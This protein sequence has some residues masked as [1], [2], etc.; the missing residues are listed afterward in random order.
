M[1]P[2]IR[3]VSL[4]ANI[5]AGKPLREVYPQF[6]GIDLPNMQQIESVEWSE[7]DLAICGL[8][9]GTAQDVIK[10]IPN[11]VRI[12]D[13]SAD[14]RLNDGNIYTKWY[15]RVHSAPE[16][17]KESVYGLSEHYRDK[18]KEARIVACPGCYPAAV[19]T[20]L[21]PLIQDGLIHPQDLIIDAKSGITGAGRS[22][23]ES[24]LFCELAESMR[25]YNV[26]HHRHIPEI[27]QEISHVA[28]V[29]I[30]V[31]FTPHLIPMN[32]GEL[33]TIYAKINTKKVENIRQSLRCFYE[34]EPFVKVLEENHIPATS[35]V[36]GSNFCLLGVFEDRLAGRVILISVL[37]NLVKGSSGQAVQNMNIMFGFDEMTGLE[38]HPLYP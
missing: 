1:H 16:L 21:L 25:P 32:G 22:L 7:V 12:I 9:H 29:D 10:K 26:A 14:F 8:P 34:D 35:H 38:Q 5:H 2:Y 30:L 24:N 36:R 13:M 37:D 31:N 18:I 19:L 11:H 17:L 20:M 4:V 3:I 23:K 33:V 27:E 15:G 6:A 28:G